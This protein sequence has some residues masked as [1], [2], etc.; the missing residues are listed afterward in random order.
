[1]KEKLSGKNENLVGAMFLE[2]FQIG[3][4]APPRNHQNPKKYRAQQGAGPTFGPIG[5]KSV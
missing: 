4:G 3:Q 2:I 5:P 1:M